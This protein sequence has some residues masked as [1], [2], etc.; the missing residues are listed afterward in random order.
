MKIWAKLLKI[1]CTFCFLVLHVNWIITTFHWHKLQELI[2]FDQRDKFWPVLADYYNEMK[3]FTL[4][5]QHHLVLTRTRIRKLCKNRNM[6]QLKLYVK[7]ELRLI[8]HKLLGGNFAGLLTNIETIIWYLRKGLWAGF[9][10]LILKQYLN[11]C[12]TVLK[13]MSYDQRR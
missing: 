7:F 12:Q 10:W 11:S 5:N 13:M 1:L 4:A 3:L 2:K 8:N 6:A 9:W